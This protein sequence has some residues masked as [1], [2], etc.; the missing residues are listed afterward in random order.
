MAP[1]ANIGERISIFEAVHGTAPDI[2]GKK[3]ANPTALLMSGLM[4]LRTLNIC[5]KAD[6]IQRG[7]EAA[8]ASGDRTRGGYIYIY[9]YK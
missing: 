8:L 9:I 3:M 1:S 6:A 2:A 4:M 5:D 7:L